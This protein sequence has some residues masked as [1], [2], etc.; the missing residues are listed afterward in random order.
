M[1]NYLKAELFR[2]FHRKY[3]W[4]YIA[5]VIGVGLVGCFGFRYM[6]HYYENTH[7]TLEVL[8]QAGISMIPAYMFLMMLFTDLSIGEEFKNNTIKNIGSS[9]LSRT[10]IYIGKVMESIILMTFSTLTSFICIVIAG[11]FIL[12]VDNGVGCI[13]L[14]KD[15]LVRGM[16]AVVLWS[17]ALTIAHFLATLIKGETTATVLY[18]GMV[19]FMED[20]FD[21]LGHYINPIFTHLQ[22]YL[23]TVQLNQI[24]TVQYLSNEVSMTAIITGLV[25]MVIVTLM[26]ILILERKDI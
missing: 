5:C 12:G 20:I 24:S 9:G 8:I 21:L 16:I 3:L 10:K 26:G 23:L 6:N 22:K 7:L 2:N 14:L 11:Y 15:C 1:R 4:G 18:I 13:N 17:G 25:Y 19:M